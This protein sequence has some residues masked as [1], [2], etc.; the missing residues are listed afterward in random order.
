MPRVTLDEADVASIR[1]VFSE[2]GLSLQ[3][4]ADRF[5]TSKQ[6]VHRLVRG[7]QRQLLPAVDVDARG[8]VTNA[9]LVMLD[10]AGYDPDED[11]LAATACALAE[12]LDSCRASDTSQSAMAAPGLARQLADTLNE[13]RDSAAD[14]GPRL[15]SLRG[16]EAVLVAQ[17]LGYPNPEQVD[18]ECFDQLEVLR[19]KRARRLL[20]Q[21]GPD[22]PQL[23]ANG[24]S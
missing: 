2:G 14:P 24:D 13:L 16:D 21:F 5:G 18:I 1:A 7:E 8:S 23:R 15:G 3:Q 19:L 6:H 11:V 22:H 12:K 9:V 17:E 4:I 10:A 20:A